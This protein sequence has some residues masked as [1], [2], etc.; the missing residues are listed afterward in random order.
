MLHLP[1]WL[2]VLALVYVLVCLPVVT[3][4][5]RSTVWPPRSAVWAVH[6]LLV[7]GLGTFLAWPVKSLMDHRTHV[8]AL[9]VDSAAGR[10][11]LVLI[12]AALLGRSS[13]KQRSQ[14]QIPSSATAPRPEMVASSSTALSHGPRPPLT[15]HPIAN[16]SRARA[17]KTTHKHQN[18]GNRVSFPY[19]V[20]VI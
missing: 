10:R 20:G 18:S 11:S 5:M 19:L 9:G 1:R 17:R 13:R 4:I 15:Q 14:K 8:T 16:L 7:F 3:H 6:G 12:V 2:H